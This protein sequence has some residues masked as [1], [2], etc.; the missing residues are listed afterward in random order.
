MKKIGC[1][2]AKAG[3]QPVRISTTPV[4]SP[5]LVLMGNLAVRF[6]NRQLLWD[7]ENQKVTNDKDA[8]AYVRRKYRE[9]WAL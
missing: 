6:P 9:G 2:R 3:Y 5:R 4:R 1:G 7:G 8:N